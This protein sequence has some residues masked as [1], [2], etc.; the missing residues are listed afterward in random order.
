MS[1]E[2]IRHPYIATVL[3]NVFVRGFVN[4]WWTSPFHQSSG[5]SLLCPKISH[6]DRILQRTV[7]QVSRCDGTVGES[8]DIVFQDRTQQRTVMKISVVFNSFSQDWVQHRFMELI[9]ETP[10]ISLAEKISE[11]WVGG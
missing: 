4:V 2:S 8:A 5:S 11:K 3:R 9:F 6:Q 1:Q 10:A 7:E